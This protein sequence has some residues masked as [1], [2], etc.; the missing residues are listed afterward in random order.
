MALR[1]ALIGEA[2]PGG[3]PGVGVACSKVQHAVALRRNQD[4]HVAGEARGPG[5]RRQE[6]GIGRLVPLAGKGHALATQERQGHRKELF[7]APHPV[8]ERDPK[9]L[10]LRLM[11]AH[12][13]P[14]DHAPVADL[15]KRGGH[16]RGD[17]RGAEAGAQHDGAQ[18][19]ALG[20]RGHRRQHGE[21]VKRAVLGLAR[22]AEHEVVVHPEAVDA[23]R[24][25]VP[26]DV[27]DRRPAAGARAV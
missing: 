27:A 18:A 10:V 15:V 26:G 11:P 2:K 21:R 6:H 4:G 23:A 24:F 7:K 13:Q 25:G 9:G 22:R 12:A 20:D 1:V 3:V 16:P 8:V 19:N 17:P 5:R 14:Q